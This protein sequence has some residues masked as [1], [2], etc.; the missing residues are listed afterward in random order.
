MKKG[1][2]EKFQDVQDFLDEFTDRLKRDRGPLN[3]LS[4]SLDHAIRHTRSQK[5]M[6]KAQKALMKPAEKVYKGHRSISNS[7]FN[8][9]MLSLVTK[10]IV[11]PAENT[12]L[13]KSGSIENY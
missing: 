9:N 7:G 13:C 2:T 10:N 4:S 12:T 6:R 1:S 11:L 5:A 3:H 8:R